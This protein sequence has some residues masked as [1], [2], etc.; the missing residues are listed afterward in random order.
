V[1]FFIVVTQKKEKGK[2]INF[3]ILV[4]SWRRFS[5]ILENFAQILKKQFGKNK[6]KFP[7]CD[8][9]HS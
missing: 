7:T 5:K 2:K 3:K 9:F 8:Q 6:I 1:K 4:Q